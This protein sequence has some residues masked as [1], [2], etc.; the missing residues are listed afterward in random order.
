VL[1]GKDKA[2]EFAWR[3]I[4]DTLLYTFKRIPE[5]ADDIVNVDNAMKWGFNWDFGP[6]EAFDL[7]GVQNFVKRCEKMESKIPEKLKKID[8]FYK[9][10]GSKNII[11]I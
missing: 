6:F 4:R 5:I 2:A 1:S 7:I 10:E 8:N 3:N 9:I 11:M